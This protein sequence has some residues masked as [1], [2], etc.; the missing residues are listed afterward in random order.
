[1][2]LEKNQTN[3]WINH[4]EEDITAIM[5]RPHY[6]ESAKLKPTEDELRGMIMAEM[7]EGFFEADGVE[8]KV[9]WTAGEHKIAGGGTYIQWYVSLTQPLKTLDL[10]DVRDVATA[11]VEKLPARFSL[12][13]RTDESTLDRGIMEKCPDCR[14]LG[15]KT[16]YS[17]YRADVE[18]E[19][20]ACEGTS[21]RIMSTNVV[22]A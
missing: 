10:V 19:C 11:V 12:Q 22:G 16:S 13:H 1:M 4:S 17:S 5:G 21:W 2:E 18:Y 8:V 14:G 15:F 6:M 7:P 20:E 3:L 9:A